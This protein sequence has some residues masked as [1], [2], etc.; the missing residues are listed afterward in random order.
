MYGWFEP[1][2]G[3]NM[4]FNFTK[5]NDVLLRTETLS[6]NIVIGNSGSLKSNAALYIYSN[7]LGIQKLPN[8]AYS[9]DVYGNTRFDNIHI[10]DFIF[11][12]DRIT[13]SQNSIVIDNFGLVQN[14]LLITNNIKKQFATLHNVTIS[15]VDIVPGTINNLHVTFTCTDNTQLTILNTNS[16]L[17]I[18][19]TLYRIVQIESVQVYVITKALDTSGFSSFPFFQNDKVDIEV[20]QDFTFSTGGD[21]IIIWFKFIAGS[22]YLRTTYA[23]FSI[24]VSDINNIPYLAQGCFYSLSKNQSLT[25]ILVLD[26]IVALNSTNFTIT[27]K[28]IDGSNF[29]VGGNTFFNSMDQMEL[30][31]LDVLY[32]NEMED[33]NVTSGIYSSP[34]EKNK[35]WIKSSKLSKYINNVTPYRSILKLTFN[36]SFSFDVQNIYNKDGRVLANLTNLN[37]SYLFSSKGTLSYQLI[38]YPFTITN[39]SESINAISHEYTY[40]FLDP[41]SI[42]SQLSIFIGHFVYVS[43]Q[44][45]ICKILNANNIENKIT[46]DTYINLVP[47]TNLYFIPFKQAFITTLGKGS[48]YVPESLAIGTKIATERLTVNGG[49]LMNGPFYMKDLDNRSYQQTY[50]GN[51]LNMNDTLLL[52]KGNRVTM[53][54]NTTVFGTVTSEGVYQFSDKKIKEKIKV[55]NKN[56]D[57]ELIKKIKIYNF[58]MK[59]GSRFQKGVIAQDIEKLLPHIVHN[60]E[61]YISSICKNGRI[62]G[63][64]STILLQDMEDIVLNDLKV[65]K[66]LRVVYDEKQFD[67]TI[68]HVHKKKKTHFIKISKHFPIGKQ[69]FVYGPWSTCK[70][71]DKDYLFMTLINAVKA[72]EAK[73]F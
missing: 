8:P 17:K 68:H 31:L 32:P 10:G 53:N 71:V 67:V 39:I 25:N 46:L 13:T 64:G 4:Y 48:C 9:L 16:F 65:G 27:L 61:G 18:K 72:L 15:S 44:N 12:N 1:G 58:D 54:T 21:G 11:N 23:T 38:G 52:E 63:C 2:G 66:I 24:T 49:I 60:T 26:S 33:M 5:F 20:Y 70:T 29:P 36:E 59:N 45:I 6:N 34:N 57:L 43:G 62:T 35:L 7:S 50:V 3:N 47:N 51:V 19:D 55:S 73:L 41:L 22:L 42:A 14:N 37:T 30:I 56:K 28:T 40:T 69:I